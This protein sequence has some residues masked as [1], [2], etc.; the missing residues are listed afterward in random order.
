MH[1]HRP[2]SA[3]K[4][5]SLTGLI[6]ILVILGAIGVLGMKIV[7]T[8]I[9]YRAITKAIVKAKESSSTV[10][11]IR[12]TFNKYADT[13]YIDSITGSDLIV[14]KIDNQY[15]VSF[16]YEKK[17]PIVGPASI[18]LEYEGTTI[19]ENLKKRLKR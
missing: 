1:H 8:V 19:P 11:G 17:I 3:Q 10:Y 18:L 9:E 7:P 2:L 15:E 16:A 12:S 4:G 13:S 6:F 14:E 5:I